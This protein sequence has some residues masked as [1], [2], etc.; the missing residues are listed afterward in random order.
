MQEAFFCSEFCKHTHTHTHKH[1]RTCIIK[2]TASFRN[3]GNLD[4]LVRNQHN[5]RKKAFDI[6]NCRTAIVS[7]E[8][9]IAWHNHNNYG[10]SWDI[11]LTSKTNLSDHFHLGAMKQ[12]YPPLCHFVVRHNYI[13]NRLLCWI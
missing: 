6:Y 4:N 12:A 7:S 10:A 1:L 5:A 13:N 8:N 3:A 11:T 2:H 9:V